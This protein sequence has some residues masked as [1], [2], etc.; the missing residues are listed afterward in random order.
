MTPQIQPG[1]GFVKDPPLFCQTL[2]NIPGHTEET[3]SVRG[4]DHTV[5]AFRT[6]ALQNPVRDPIGKHFGPRL[7]RIDDIAQL[8]QFLH[9]LQS[10]LAVSNTQNT[11]QAHDAAN[12]HSGFYSVLIAAISRC[13]L[14][15]RSPGYKL[16]P[17]TQQALQRRDFFSGHFDPW[18]F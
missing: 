6:G 1:I 2:R 7:Q 14:P 13:S 9:D 10:L 3:I 5:A 16:Q 18:E 17:V 4:V 12:P 8:L 11:F 15:K